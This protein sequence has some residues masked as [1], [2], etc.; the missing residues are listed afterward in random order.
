VCRP[1]ETGRSSRSVEELPIEPAG[2]MKR[3]Q[4]IL[5]TA[6]VLHTCNVRGSSLS[7]SQWKGFRRHPGGHSDETLG[8]PAPAPE[9][10]S[11]RR[12]SFSPA[13]SDEARR[14]SGE[15]DRFER[16]RR[17]PSVDRLSVG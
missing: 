4:L 15:G 2:I 8:P 7:G 17:R 11:E 9:G 13:L 10:V 3:V 14:M 6:Q 5:R 12:D 1:R 16:L